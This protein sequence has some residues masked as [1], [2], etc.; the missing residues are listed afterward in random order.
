MQRVKTV[1]TWTVATLTVFLALYWASQIGA[2]RIDSY[3][4]G[5]P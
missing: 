3:L 4:Q 2:A 1:T 5:L